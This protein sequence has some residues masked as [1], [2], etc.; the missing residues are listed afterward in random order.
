M[1]FIKSFRDL[2]NRDHNLAIPL[3]INLVHPCSILY[4]EKKD[5]SAIFIQLFLSAASV[6]W[7]MVK[8][9]IYFSRIFL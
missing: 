9:N 8:N 7:W 3:C 2:S 5:V 6:C 1:D 4:E